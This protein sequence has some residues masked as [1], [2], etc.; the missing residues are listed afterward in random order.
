MAI[1]DGT[2]GK[3]VFQAQHRKSGD[4]VHERDQLLNKVGS[5]LAEVPYRK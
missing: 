1:F 3:L 5:A 2:D 4:L